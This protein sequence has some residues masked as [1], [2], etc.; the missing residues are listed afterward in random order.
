MR[1]TKVGDPFVGAHD[2]PITALHL[3]DTP[4]HDVILEAQHKQLMLPDML[5]DPSGNVRLRR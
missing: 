4:F 2:L 1:D 3:F 5:H